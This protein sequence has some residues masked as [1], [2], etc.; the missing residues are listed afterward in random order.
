M[1]VS[2]FKFILAQPFCSIKQSDVLSCPRSK[3]CEFSPAIVLPCL[4]SNTLFV[5]SE[6]D[7]DE[8]YAFLKLLKQPKDRRNAN[9]VEVSEEMFVRAVKGSKKNSALSVFSGRRYAV[10]EC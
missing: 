7:T 8:L 10:Y 3:V 4:S 1:F 6:C 5:S 9:V 2:L